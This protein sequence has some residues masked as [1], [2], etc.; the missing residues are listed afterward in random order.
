MYYPIFLVLLF[1]FNAQLLS[2][3]IVNENHPIMEK[4]LHSLMLLRGNR[5]YRA[6]DL[7]KY[8]P[9]GEKQEWY[10]RYNVSERPE[11]NDN[12]Y[13]PYSLAYY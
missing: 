7:P 3:S 6:K 4:R 13:I 10:W 9:K 2:A 8:A 11:K 1:V 5:L 12:Y